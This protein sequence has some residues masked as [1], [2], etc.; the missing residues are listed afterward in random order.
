MLFRSS[1]AFPSSPETPCTM[2]VPC[3]HLALPLVLPVFSGTWG[4]L[5]WEHR[6]SILERPQGKDPQPLLLCLSFQARAKEGQLCCFPQDPEI[7]E[8]FG[9]HGETVPASRPLLQCCLSRGTVS[10]VAG[11][12]PLLSPPT[13]PR[14]GLLCLPTPQPWANVWGGHGWAGGVGS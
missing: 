6:S 3:W 13:P 5:G 7:K 10:S 12:Q 11:P 2:A 4:Q 1:P 14:A 9:R 8:Q